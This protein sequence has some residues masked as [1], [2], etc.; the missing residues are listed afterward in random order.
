VPH[1]W[2]DDQA[3]EAVELYTSLFPNGRVRGLARYPETGQEIHGR[4]PGSVMNVDFELAGFRM[5][6]LNGGP[7]FRFTP[8]IS[9]FVTVEEKPD[10]DRLWTALADGGTALMPLDAYDWSPRYGWIQDRF[11]LSWQLSQG[12]PGD[13]GAT[14]VPALMFVTDQPVAETA[15]RRYASV[16]DDAE[17]GAVHHYPPGVPGGLDGGVMHGRFRLAGQPFTTM[18]ASAGMHDF[19]FTEAISLLVDC[20]S[21]E[22]IDRYWEGL[23]EGGDPRAQQCGWLKDAFG[24]SW[25]VNPNEL[26]EMLSD[27][28]RER[29]ERVAEAFFEMKKFDLAALRKAYQA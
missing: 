7:H 18:D 15:M 5:L 17:A 2:F 4:P 21:Q 19:G 16:F 24:V 23:G 3:E 8:A 29:A 28:D 14:I 25:Q 13:I 12:D 6:A 11:G 1:L 26:G 20:D 10:V 27:P 9:F 22:E